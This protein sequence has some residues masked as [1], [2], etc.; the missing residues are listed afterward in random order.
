MQSQERLVYS[1][2]E[3]SEGFDDA[4]S[5]KGLSFLKAYLE[6]GLRIVVLF[7]FCDLSKKV[8]EGEV[9]YAVRVERYSGNSDTSSALLTGNHVIDMHGSCGR[10]D[11]HMLVGDVEHM[12]SDQIGAIPSRVR[13]YHIDNVVNDGAAGALTGLVLALNGTLKVLPSAL[14]REGKFGMLRDGVPVR[15]D[16]NTVRVIE[17]GPEVVQGIAEDGGCVPGEA[18]DNPRFFPTVTVA[19]G[20]KTFFVR[21]DVLPENI[22][23][24]RDVMVGPLGL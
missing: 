15:F 24:V 16:Q 7:D 11:D 13:L 8:I 2:G 21:T 17:G 6:G 23:K 12:E 14:H 18:D 4:R 22:F 19:L 1:F 9:G 3:R 10:D 5:L 20:P